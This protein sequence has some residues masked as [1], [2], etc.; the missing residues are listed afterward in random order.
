MGK[1]KERSGI[2][3]VLI[4]VE[5]CPDGALQ[6][7]FTQQHPP[8]WVSP[9]MVGLGEYRWGL[10]GQDNLTGSTRT[11]EMHF[12]VCFS[13]DHSTCM[14]V[15]SWLDREPSEKRLLRSLR[16]CCTHTEMYGIG[17]FLSSNAK[18]EDPFWHRAGLVTWLRR[19]LLEPET[20][21]Y[22]EGD[23]AGEEL[24]LFCS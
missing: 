15:V 3:C 17:N 22:F 14:R 2:S 24:L 19:R 9:G 5:E 18:G 16:V 6:G 4:T 21:L 12:W 1:R 23:A 20:M 11:D 7:H 13:K 8:L 10:C